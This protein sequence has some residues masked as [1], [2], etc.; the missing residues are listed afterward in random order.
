MNRV[1]EM[2]RAHCQQTE[3]AAAIGIH[4]DTLSKRCNQEFKVTL[5][6]YVQQRRCHG[7]A[8]LRELQW[9]T[10]TTTEVTSTGSIIPAKGAA[11]MQI[12]LGK[13]W[14]KQH[15]KL[16]TID[17]HWA[18]RQTSDDLLRLGK[19]ALQVL[20]ASHAKKESES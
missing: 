4:V 1:D 18:D 11:T 7:K 14:L 13:Q 15:D 16:E 20:E 8:A 3:I 10:A 12:W 9:H 5:S 2:A 19:E 6:E 17:A